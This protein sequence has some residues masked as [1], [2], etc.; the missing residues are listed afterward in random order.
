MS[1][2]VEVIAA[3]PRAAS[4]ERHYRPDSL[5]ALLGISDKLIGEAVARYEATQGRE[6]LGPVSRPSRAVVLIPE[7]AAARW[8][9][10][11][12][13]GAAV[14]EHAQLSTWAERLDVSPEVLQAAMARWD[15]SPPQRR[16]GLGPRV[17]LGPKVVLL[18][19]SAVRAWLARGLIGAAA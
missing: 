13:P 3:A 12:L 9:G 4:V 18:S 8:I 7:W 17:R 1:E 16:E 2:A 11:S 15:A 6:G 14:E 19:A 5:A 10:G